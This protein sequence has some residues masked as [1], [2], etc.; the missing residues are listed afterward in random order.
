MLSHFSHVWLFAIPSPVSHWAPLS[1]G[2]SRQEYWRGLPC[3]S[4]GDLT[5]SGFKPMSVMSPALA[6]G[7]FT[8]SATWEAPQCLR[9]KSKWIS[10]GK[11]V[12]VQSL[13]WDTHQ[14]L[15]SFEQ[16]ILSRSQEYMQKYLKV[17]DQGRRSITL[18]QAELV[19]RVYLQKQIQYSEFSVSFIAGFNN[20][21][22]YL[23]KLWL[24]IW[25]V[26][27]ELER[28]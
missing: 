7:F 14:N 22:I 1:M 16:V 19:K 23:T 18:D 27:N 11:G 4:S 28:L 5:H 9:F 8:T 24:Q 3:S 25:L 17:V 15:V 12:Q 26:L 21:F 6:G 2:Y 10:F 13:Y 20:I